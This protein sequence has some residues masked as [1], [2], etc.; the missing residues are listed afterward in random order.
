MTQCNQLN[1]P[2]IIGHITK[3]EER[4]Y[5]G[6]VIKMP[7]GGVFY[8]SACAKSLGYNVKV[9]TKLSR[10]DT[11]LVE[12]LTI[13]KQN[14]TFIESAKT[15]VMQNTYTTIEKT[16]RIE[17]CVSQ[18][19]PF[20]LSDILTNPSQLYQIAGLLYGDFSDSLLIAL[21][22]QGD[23]AVDAQGL[24]RHR[25]PVTGLMSYKDYESKT[26]L[27]PHIKYLKAGILEASILAELAL[28]APA[29]TSPRSRPAPAHTP[30]SAH[31]SPLS[32]ASSARAGAGAPETEVTP[33][34]IKTITQKLHN[35][36][37]KEI[38]LT[39]PT[40]VIASDTSTIEIQHIQ[41]NTFIGRTGRGDTAF[42][43]YINERASGN[44]IQDSLLITKNAVSLKMQTL[45]VLNCTRKEIVHYKK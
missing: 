26:T 30:S 41:T 4:D 40:S 44:N 1:P 14:I 35:L 36:G 13:P 43:A 39:T 8:A 25:D 12:K 10:D 6:N 37:I 33:E 16:H 29:S 9:I 15:T 24:L 18:A 23:V 45:G 34:Y 22:K 17:T 20:T 32:P 7:G 21:S 27:F 11:S 3:D 19:D 28:P 31:P 42:T 2:L 38:L 5:L